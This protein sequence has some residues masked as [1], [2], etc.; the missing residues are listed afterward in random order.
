V[1]NQIETP[2]LIAGGGPVGMTLALN[3]ARYGVRT[4]LVERNTATTRHPKM[5]LT[6]GRSMELFRRLGLT[7]KLRDAGVP[8]ENRFDISWVTSMAGHELHRFKYPS[9]AENTEL[10]RQ[11]NDGSYA[12]EA[13]LRVSQIV[14]EP[15]L[16]Q[17]IDEN[18]LIDVRFGTAFERLV[19]Q[20]D[21]GVTVEIYNAE[22]DRTEVVRSQYLAGCD[23]GGSRVR[24]QIGV[25]LDGDMAVAGA[26]MV[27]FRSPDREV[28]QRWGTAW[29][30]QSGRGTVI[31]QDDEE[32]YT[33]QAWLI[34]GLGIDTMSPEEVLEGWVGQKFNYE[35]LLSNPWTANF[36]VAQRYRLGRVLLAGDSA[37]QFVPT[38]G[39]GMNSGVA[40]A[41]GLAWVLAAC[42]QGWGGATL[43]DAYER[44]R[45]PTAWWHL[46]ASRRH[47]GVRMALG[48]LYAEAGDLDGVGPQADAKRAAIG[49]RIAELGNAENE[50][51]GVE[52]GY[53]YEDSPVIV[54]DPGEAPPVVPITYVPNTW[55]GSRLPHVFLQDGQSVYD[56]L[57]LYFTLLA[58]DT[59]DASPIEAVARSLGIP[60]EVLQLK[61]PDLLA[62]Y[63]RAFLLIRPDH[64]IAWRGDVLP[65]DLSL[66]FS[67]AAGRINESIKHGEGAA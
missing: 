27:H 25:T 46:E 22:A 66:L 8:R 50:S 36:V 35:I 38:G 40:D 57:G 26:H 1:A 4:I 52:L 12:V 44:E 42:I 30:Y 3:L 56:K 60:L 49:Q 61:R 67:T 2:V 31:A 9:A 29:H 45:R 15:V 10:I 7:E 17:A 63:Q 65:Q 20:D 11:R 47:M 41:A 6:N 51:W 18:P 13:P 62:V 34:P 59:V 64:H 37:H 5:D 23:G 53:R 32:I 55:P 33:L 43:L 16:K 39:Y 24:R 54:K 28:L 48:Q 21:S 19:A 58:I 14:I